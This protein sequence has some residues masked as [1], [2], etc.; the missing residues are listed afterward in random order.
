MG[1]PER[2]PPSAAAQLVRAYTRAV[3]YDGANS[4]M[5]AAVFEGAGEIEVPVTLAW[6]D[7]DRLVRPPQG[8]PPGWRSEVLHDCGHVPTWDDPEQVARLILRASA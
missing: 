2:V 5:R 8:V 3:S 1:H 7:L 6:G 4:A